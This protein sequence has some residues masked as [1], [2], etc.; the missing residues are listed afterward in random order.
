MQV[1]EGSLWSGGDKKFR[2][3][4]VAEAAGHT[5]VYYRE[6]PN[7]YASNKES[8]EYSCYIESFVQRFNSIPE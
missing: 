1:K 3:I 2:V 5:W 7:K 8:N 4:S 6:E